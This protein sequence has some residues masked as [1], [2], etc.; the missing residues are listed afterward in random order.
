MEWSEEKLLKLI[1]A[2][3]SKPL[4]WDTK[5]KDHYRKN[6]KENAWKEISDEIKV[7]EAACKKKMV[8]LL[9]SHRRERNRIRCSKG[10]GRDGIYKSRWFAYEAFK[11][12]GDKDVPRKRLTMETD[13]IVEAEDDIKAAVIPIEQIEREATQME[14]EP[15][16]SSTLRPTKRARGKEDNINSSILENAL[17]NSPTTAKKSEKR[18]SEPNEIDSFFTYVAV[19]VHKYSP[20]VQKRVQHSVFDILMK[21]DTGMLDW[22]S[23][24]VYSQPYFSYQHQA[25][26]HSAYPSQ[27]RPSFSTNSTEQ[28]PA[29]SIASEDVE[30]FV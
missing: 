8:S 14:R 25:V 20:E 16:A 11:F 21:A 15:A 22:P 26:P 23:S 5:H 24:P 3:K 12:L 6:A 27:S 29:A 10:K 7:S 18:P 1:E 2:Y 30:D 19:K 13:G 28:S 4:L 9:A 17:N